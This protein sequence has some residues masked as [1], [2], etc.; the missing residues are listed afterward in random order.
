MF[1]KFQRDNQIKIVEELQKRRQVSGYLKDDTFETSPATQRIINS[2][3]RAASIGGGPN[4]MLGQT[5]SKLTDP[6]PSKDSFSATTLIPPP[7][8]SSTA[9]PLSSEAEKLIN[10]RMRRT[11][12]LANRSR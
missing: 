7:Q 11:N 2:P 10:A 12:D 8:T 9:N 6:N 4:S 5:A 1:N 3:R